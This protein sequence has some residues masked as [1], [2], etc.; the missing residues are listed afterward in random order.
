MPYRFA[1]RFAVLAVFALLLAAFG[2]AKA[3]YTNRSQMILMSSQEE[4]A[5]G[6]QASRQV[7]AEAK[8]ET[9]T[10]A[11]AMTRRVGQRIAA[12][13]DEPDPNL[14]ARAKF[15]WEFHTLT[16]DTPNA[17][18]LPGGKIFVYTGLLKY[19][20]TDAEL[21]AVIGHEVG[22][23]IARHGAE[24]ASQSQAAGLVGGVGSA[25]LGGAGGQVFNAAYG[26]GVNYGILMP[27]SR[28][29]ES[30]AD[31]IGLLL[32]AKAGY[33]PS[34][35]LSFW[36]K[37]ATAGGSKPPEWMSTHPSD[38]SRI[39]EIKRQLPEAMAIYKARQGNATP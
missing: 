26:L 23:A 5:L 39:A 30:E 4:L 1:S 24:R 13:A 28:L 19:A 10:P 17:F 22:H 31:Y 25:I 36:Q 14:P 7:L 15:D 20:A 12:A 33:D 18:C 6:M 16:S 9:N 29:Q 8:E 32:M 2:C 38:E 11:A 3:P 35:A 34:A 21:A 27:Y 37:M